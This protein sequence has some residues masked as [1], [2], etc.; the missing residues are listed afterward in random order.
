MITPLE[1]VNN[2]TQLKENGNRAFKDQN[3]SV[4]Y[5]YYS[6]AIV[7]ENDNQQMSVLYCNRAAVHL[8]TYDYIACVADCDLAIK[9]LPSVKAYFRRAR[10]NLFLKEIKEAYKDLS[11]LLRL[12]SKNSDAISLMRTVK[13]GEY[14]CTRTA[15]YVYIYAHKTANISTTITSVCMY[16]CIWYVQ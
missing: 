8:K 11:L 2:A 1:P 15:I 6:Q 3:Y 14:I 12:D 7:I 16:N 9:I 5:D 10:A 13:A 4:A